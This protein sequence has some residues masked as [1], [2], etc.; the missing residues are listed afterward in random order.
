MKGDAHSAPQLGQVPSE[1]HG[2]IQNSRIAQP[3]VSKK[4]KS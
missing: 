2:L 4:L 3:A 1:Q